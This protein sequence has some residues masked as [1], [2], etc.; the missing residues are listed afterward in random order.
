MEDPW[1]PALAQAQQ[2]GFTREEA[3]MALVVLGSAAPQDKVRLLGC[4]CLHC[5]C[6]SECVV[7]H[8][9]AFFRLLC[10]TAH[11]KLVWSRCQKCMYAFPS[12]TPRSVCIFMISK[13][14][15]IGR[16]CILHF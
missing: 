5:S 9:L 15:S 6:L 16:C 1:A 10:F 3:A 14:P 7:L 13:Q 11:T 12:S 4:C 2:R 8:T